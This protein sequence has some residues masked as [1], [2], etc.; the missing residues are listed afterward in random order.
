MFL[1]VSTNIFNMTANQKPWKSGVWPMRGRGMFK[2]LP[3]NSRMFWNVLD[4][5]ISNPIYTTDTLT[6]V[7]SL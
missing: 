4:C 1:Q 7:I 2:N 5:S 6:V 3:A